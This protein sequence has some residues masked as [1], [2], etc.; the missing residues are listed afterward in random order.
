MGKKSD[1]K[2]TMAKKDKTGEIRA[3]SKD[4]A[5]FK[6]DQAKKYE[7]TTFDKTAPAKIEGIHFIPV[8]KVKDKIYAGEVYE[9]DTTTPRQPK[10]VA[11]NHKTRTVGRNK[12]GC[13]WK[14][15]T[16]TRSLGTKKTLNNKTWEKRVVER[17]QKKVLQERLNKLRE[18][19][20]EAK[21]KSSK[22]YRDKQERKKV[23][24]M[25]SAKY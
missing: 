8:S 1:F 19:R 4:Q 14:K 16:S 12:S 20:A 11:E 22:N 18:E 5:W 15:G 9:E 23:N 17:Q 13:L 21:K 25:R 24:E 7:Q 3:I 2:K 6:E 10:E